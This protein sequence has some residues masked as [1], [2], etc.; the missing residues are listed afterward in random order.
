MLLGGVRGAL[1]A[2]EGVLGTQTWTPGD[3][4]LLSLSLWRLEMRITRARCAF[5]PRGASLM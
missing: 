3:P 2:P 1:R 5:G 4:L